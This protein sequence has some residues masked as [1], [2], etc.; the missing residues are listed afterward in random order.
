MAG[1]GAGGG[2]RRETHGGWERTASDGSCNPS[3]G[4]KRREKC[5]CNAGTLLRGEAVVVERM[6]TLVKRENCLGSCTRIYM[7]GSD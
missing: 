6:A 4:D 7:K 2:G 3:K 5:G 1:G